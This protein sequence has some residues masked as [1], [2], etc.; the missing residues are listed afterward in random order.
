M[1]PDAT[2]R[3]CNSCQKSVIDFTAKTDEE[4][5]QFILNNFNQPLCGRFKNTQVQ[6]IVID[7]PKNI[8]SIKM[9]LWMRFLVACLLIFGISIFPFETTIAGKT[10]VATAFYQG[11]PIKVDTAK[12]TK[13]FKKKKK[14][15]KYIISFNPVKLT[16]LIDH[17]VL[18][19]F[20]LQGYPIIKSIFDLPENPFDEFA[21][22]MAPTETNQQNTSLPQKQNPGPTPYLP[23]EFILPSILLF[24]KENNNQTMD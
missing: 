4:I 9:P 10:P 19:G 18:G 16:P 13:V 23:T 3:Y 22:N 2:G 7:L 15:S 14:R 5:Q 17:M 8:F 12:K 20:G 6:R 11:E 1:I 24:R 21:F